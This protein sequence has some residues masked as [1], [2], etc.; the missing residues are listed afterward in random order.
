LEES[1]KKWE[2]AKKKK[3]EQRWQSRAQSKLVGK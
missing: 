3:K 2:E 1:P